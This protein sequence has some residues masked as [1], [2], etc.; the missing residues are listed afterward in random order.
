MTPA[1]N[2][3][4]CPTVQTCRS[5]TPC[6][7]LRACKISRLLLAGI[8]QHDFVQLAVMRHVFCIGTLRALHP[9][10]NGFRADRRSDIAIRIAVVVYNVPPCDKWR[11]VLEIRLNNRVREANAE[12][13]LQASGDRV[14]CGDSPLPPGND[15]DIVSTLKVKIEKLFSDALRNRSLV[16][17]LVDEIPE[18]VIL[19][20]L[21]RSQCSVVF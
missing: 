2:P 20:A 10:R 17:L 11:L 21:R 3:A 18:L 8:L 12:H 1:K 9:D 15:I 7:G 5:L 13:P 14:S 4:R 6:V 16:I 19:P